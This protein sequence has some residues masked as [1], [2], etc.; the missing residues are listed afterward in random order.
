MNNRPKRRKH[1]DNPYTLKVKDDCYVASFY[2]GNEF[3]SIEVNKEVFN[4]LDRFEL[5]DLK[6]LNERDNHRDYRYINDDVDEILI[7]NDISEYSDSVEEIIEN[8][9]FNEDLYKAINSLN[10]I[11]KNRIKKYY[12]E[13]KTL[14][15]IALEEGCSPR[16][17]I[18]LKSV[19]KIL[20]INLKFRLQKLSLS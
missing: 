6:E 7:F 8:K 9:L 13:N 19:L 11:Q 12:F 3:V 5:D 15:E 20:E 18:V 14:N 10:D 2:N 1:K 17:I 4:L 16:A